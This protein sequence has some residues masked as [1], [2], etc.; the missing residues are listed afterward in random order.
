MGRRRQDLA[1]DT[2][3]DPPATTG[4]G[5]TAEPRDF[6]SVDTLAGILRVD[7]KTVYG[8]IADGTIK[9]LRLGRIIRI[10]A[11]AIAKLAGGALAFTGG[12]RRRRSR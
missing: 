6:F 1:Q 3:D 11:A 9:A 12:R 7:R 4:S 5:A 10:P 2:I 8:A